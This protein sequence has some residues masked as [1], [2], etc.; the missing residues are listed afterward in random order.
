MKKMFGLDVNHYNYNLDENNIP[1][2]I[3]V[4]ADEATL[5]EISKYRQ[6]PGNF[7]I[8]ECSASEKRWFGASHVG[9]FSRLIPW[10]G[11]NSER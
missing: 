8:T 4:Y 9:L 1:V 7:C 6:F 10:E 3:W 5:I 11:L 2:D